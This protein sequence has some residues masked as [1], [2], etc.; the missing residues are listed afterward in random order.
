LIAKHPVIGCDLALVAPAVDQ[1]RRLIKRGIDEMGGAPQ[2]RSRAGALPGV[3]QI[4]LNITSTM[5]FARPSARQRDDFT[6]PDAPKCRKAAFPTSPVAPA[7]TTFLF[8]IC[9]TPGRGCFGAI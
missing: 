7:T 6:S 3:R 2:W 4:G 5:E 1:V 9:R 8:F